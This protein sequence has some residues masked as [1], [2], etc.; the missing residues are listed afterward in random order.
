VGELVREESAVGDVRLRQHRKVAAVAL[1]LIGECDPDEAGELLNRSFEVR[2]MLVWPTVNCHTVHV[3][4]PYSV[5][6]HSMRDG[7]RSGG[8]HARTRTLTRRW[9]WSIQVAQELPCWGGL[10]NRHLGVVDWLRLP[11]EQLLDQA[12]QP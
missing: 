3:T 7:R 10:P 12:L 9:L 4:V 8:W 5:H 1:Q 6:I 2:V 11:A